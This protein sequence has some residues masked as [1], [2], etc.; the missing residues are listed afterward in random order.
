MLIRFSVCC[1]RHLRLVIFE[2]GADLN[3]L[4]RA[5]PQRNVQLHACT[6]VGRAR[7]DELVQRRP[8]ARR[9]C[10]RELA[11]CE[12][13]SRTGA[14][15]LVRR[16]ADVGWVLSSADARAAVI[17][18]EIKRRLQT[19]AQRLVAEF[20]LFNWTRDSTSSARW[21]NASF[22]RSS[23]GWTCSFCGTSIVEVGTTSAFASTGSCNVRLSAFFMINCCNW[24]LVLATVSA[25]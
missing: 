23:V 15:L 14:K 10:E 13:R 3:R 5:V 8:V 9:R 12:V 16:L 4:C 21:R 1:K 17:G 18:K 22:T 6:F 20:R 2:F 7:V 11:H 19:A 25:C 24:R